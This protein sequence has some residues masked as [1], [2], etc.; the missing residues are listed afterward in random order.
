MIL[1]KTR[2]KHMFVVFRE[3]HF[4]SKYRSNVFR[5][6]ICVLSGEGCFNF[7]GDNATPHTDWEGDVKN[8]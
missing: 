5:T 2:S 3:S 8:D 1:N 6:I 4:T 7:D